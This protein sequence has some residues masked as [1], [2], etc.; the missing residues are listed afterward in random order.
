MVAAAASPQL[1]QKSKTHHQVSA[2]KF[3]FIDL[4]LM[5]A[6]IHTLPVKTSDFS[7]SLSRTLNSEF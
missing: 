2:A 6:S 5:D 1:R 7:L 4:F 3:L